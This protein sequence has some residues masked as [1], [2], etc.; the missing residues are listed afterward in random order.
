[1]KRLQTSC[2]L[3]ATILF[4]IFFFS[5]KNE[6]NSDS[7]A[8]TEIGGEEDG[9][10]ALKREAWFQL[11]HSA[12][13]GVNWEDIE[14][15]NQMEIYKN[16]LGAQ[17]KT[18][19]TEIAGGLIVGEWNERGSKNQ[20]GSVFETE[21][22]AETEEIWVLGAGGSLFKGALAGQQWEVVNQDLRF[23][24]G[25]LKFIPTDTGRRLLALTNK[26]PHYSDDDGKTWTASTGIPIGDRWMT[27][28][29][30][31]I[32]NDSL[33]SILIL[34]KPD[35][36]TRATL[37]ISKD[38]GETFSP[39]TR[40]RSSEFND[41]SLCQPHHSD[42]VYLMEKLS[43]SFK[44]SKI[45]PLTE[46]ITE[47]QSGDQL[48]FEDARANLAA[49]Q[50][51]DSLTRFVVYAGK[52]N[53]VNTFIS[54][55][56]GETWEQRGQLESMP[57]QVGLYISPST[58][59]VMFVGEL[60]CQITR[61]GGQTWQRKNDWWAYYDNVDG[62][63]HA[64]MMAFAEFQKKDGTPFQLISNH[65]GLSITYDQ[66]RNVSNLSLE[67]LNVSQYYSVRTDPTD[68][69]FIYGGTQD[70]GFQ[71]ANT[72]LS[73][74]EADFEQIISGDYGH[75][76]FSQFGNRL[77][78]VY[79]G[80]SVTVYTAPR[81][82]DQRYG[83]ELESEDESVWIPPLMPSPDQTENAVYLAGGNMNGGEG[84]HIIKLTNVLNNIYPLQ[85]PFDFKDESAGGEVSAITFSEAD[86]NQ[87]YAATTNGR[88]FTSKDAGQ[89]WEQSIGFIPE[90][91]YLYGQALQA[92]SKDS[93][94]VFLAGSGYS[95][96]ACYMST[97]G[98]F[99]FIDMADGLPNTLIFDLAFN[100]DET[101]LFAATEAGPYIFIVEEEKWYYLGGTDAPVQTYWSVEYVPFSNT[102]RFGTYGRG[103]WDFNIQEVTGIKKNEIATSN[104]KLYPNP[105]NGANVFIEIP[106]EMRGKFQ[107]EITNA[108]GAIVQKE[109]IDF[110]TNPTNI[111]TNNLPTG[112]YYITLSGEK[113]SFTKKL[114]ISN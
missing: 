17:S 81:S 44:I 108:S 54:E 91:H 8:P 53:Y 30:P 107:I 61:N 93:D 18:G 78:T 32:L 39:I 65:G 114:I 38:N 56:F 104:I 97:D 85:L 70:Q 50:L 86:K 7:P 98:G 9:D 83:W 109:E 47:I 21:F 42:E 5:C 111:T 28:R 75:I 10:N 31:I 100:E 26:V 89:T 77:W 71:R 37:Y 84:S 19:T 99:T 45:E 103:I 105:S 20:A 106:V 72:A 49:V 88:F 95:N 23:N 80:G 63:L 29:N 57:W 48:K 2:I 74:D 25:L 14:Y 68:P 90:G 112:S 11:M 96:P 27:T 59:E 66:G 22:D 101:L 6:I 46:Q 12:A 40:M 13:P 55:D 24:N 16:R 33:N 64:D 3:A 41:Y 58:P 51:S 79:P 92:S 69:Y 94:L 35:Y 102:A 60:H 76:V 62:A 113:G 1:M 4:A 36:W 110:M 15:K 67:G 34:S 73:P 87:W 82:T 52:D 43:N